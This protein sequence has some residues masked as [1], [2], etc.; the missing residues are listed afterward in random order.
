MSSAMY[1]RTMLSKS[2]SAFMPSD[3]PSFGAKFDGHVDDDAVDRRVELPLARDRRP[4]RRRRVRSAATMSPTATQMPGTLTERV[5]ANARRRRL[6]ADDQVV[7]DRARRLHPHLRRRRDRADRVDAG[8]RLADDAARE[9][10]RGLVRLARPHGDRRQAQR[11]AVDEALA[12]HV[13]DEVFA[14]RLLR[15]VRRLRRERRVVGHRIGQRAAEHRERARE[16]E[17]GRRRERAAALEQRARRVEVH[18]HADVEVGLGLAADDGGEM[19]HRVGVGRDGARDDGRIGE[20]AGDRRDA[21]VGGEARRARRRAARSRDLARAARGVG[22]GAA[23][24]QLAGE[25]GAEEAGAAGDHD[26][27]GSFVSSMEGGAMIAA[28][29]PPAKSAPA[30]RRPGR[31]GRMLEFFVPVRGVRFGTS[32]RRPSA[33]PVSMPP[34]H[35]P[36]A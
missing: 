14:D 16:H 15:A 32:S 7:D 5:C 4:R 30:C 28:R 22:E 9:R 23:L 17:L 2:A 35:A 13:V 24:E 18:A 6:V 27:H 29:R 10:R 20:V 21:R 12:R 11:A 26:A 19:E 31:R 34:S 1:A 25:A 3:G 33:G 8:Q 36:A